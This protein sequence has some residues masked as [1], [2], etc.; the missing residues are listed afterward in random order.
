MASQLLHQQQQSLKHQSSSDHT[1]LHPSPDGADGFLTARDDSG[2]GGGKDDDR[3]VAGATPL[4]VIADDYDAAKLRSITPS[5]PPALSNTEFTLLFVGLALAVFLAALDQTI[6]AVALGAIAQEFNALGQITWIAT[7]Y[8][9]TST[10]FIPSYGQLADIFGRKSVFLFAIIVFEIGSAMCGAATNM[11]MLIASRAIAGLGGGGIFS[12]VV[13]I[14]ADIVPAQDRGKYN[15]LVGACF[16]IA[17]VAGP[18]VG[19]AFVDKVSW[20]WVFYINLPLGVITV[21]AVVALLKLPRTREGDVWSS[22][23]RIDWIGT[24]LLVGAVI[25]ILIPLQGVGSLYAWRDA[26]VVALLVVGAV[27]VVAFLYVEANWAANPVVP[28]SMF[29]D[30][31]LLA[32]M[33]TSFF[34]GCA[35][36][37]LVFYLPTWFQV[38]LG[39][40]AT[41]AGVRTI[42]LIMGVVVFSIVSGFVSSTTGHAYPFL[43]VG[44]TL[45][46]LGAALLSTLT[47]SSPLWS[48]ILFPLIAGAGVGCTIQIVILVAQFTTRPDQLAVVTA[49][50]NFFQSIG[51]VVGLAICSVSFNSRLQQ[52]VYANLDAANMT[53]TFTVPYVDRETF[54][55]SAAFIRSAIPV[56]E[57]GPVIHGYV[58][59]LQLMF[60]AAVAFAACEIGATLFAR[61]GKISVEAMAEM[62]PALA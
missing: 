38:V 25:C 19:G 9:L 32:A 37:T 58:Q 44:A 4:P 28:L 23:S 45:T 41:Q 13:I 8:F 61:K 15:G 18:L 35:F 16:G 50:V 22:L 27:L 54:F 56:E 57:Q 29:R 62:G 6:V 11:N 59:T 47:E 30:T 42:P 52:N 40:T 26:I 46:C 3:T 53:L 17:S 55:Q 33:L 10:A 48:E 51:A 5:T 31:K 1:L 2:T 24:F 43:P 49:N 20:R 12:L 60:Y 21:A 39:V 36:F 7:A 14:I 34:G